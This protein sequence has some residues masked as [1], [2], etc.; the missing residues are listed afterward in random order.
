[1]ICSNPISR[2]GHPSAFANGSHIAITSGVRTI[3]GFSSG[4]SSWSASKLSNRPHNEEAG[5][6]ATGCR[7][8]SAMSDWASPLETTEPSTNTGLPPT[9][10][11]S[12]LKRL[13]S[14]TSSFSFSGE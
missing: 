3:E 6:Q 7:S 4:A 10:S 9:V 11:R 12:A 2:C 8:P 1:M 5:D 13:M 14:G